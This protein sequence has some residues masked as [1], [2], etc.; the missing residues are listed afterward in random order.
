MKFVNASRLKNC[1]KTFHEVQ[2]RFGLKNGFKTFHEVQ[3]HLGLKN[4]SKT[5][6]EVQKRFRLKNCSKMFHEVQKR[7]GLKNCSKTLTFLNCL[8]R[9]LN[10]FCPGRFII[11]IFST[12]V[13][14][15][16]IQKQHCSAFI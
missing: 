7:F 14:Y 13:F 2:K 3:K 12:Q 15:I 5:F 16:F 6:H 1:S 11:T 10:T 8:F 9:V 4:C